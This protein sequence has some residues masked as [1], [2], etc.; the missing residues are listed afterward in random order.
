M[1]KKTEHPQLAKG[2][3]TKAQQSPP[4]VDKNSL[5]LQGRGLPVLQLL[6]L[7]AVGLGLFVFRIA[8]LPLVD[9]DE[10]RCA[11]IVQEMQAT[12]NWLV[13]H[14]EGQLYFDKP[15]P[16]FWLAALV[17]NVTGS[18]EL[19]GRLIAA[20]AGLAAVLVSWAWGRRIFGNLAGLLAGLVLATSVE[21]FFIARW[22]RMDMPFV[23]AIWA[24]IW[25]LWRTERSGAKPSPWRGW[26]GFYALAG[27]ATLFKG[28]AGLGLPML[29]V[30][31]YLLVSGQSR[32]LLGMFHPLGIGLYLLIAAPW[33]V[34]ISLA[35]PGY[36]YEFFV[37]QN[38]FR[39]VGAGNLGHKWP[40]ILYVPILLAGLLPWTIYLPGAVV[41]Y[42]PRRWQQLKQ[43]SEFLLLW[44]IALVTVVFFSFSTTKLPSY[45][46]L[47]FPPLAILIGGLIAEWISTPAPDL[48]LRHSAR[49]LLTA[50]LVIAPLIL[51]G[52]EVYLQS[53][54]LWIVLPI[55][56]SVFAAWRMY[57]SLVR[58]NR[59]MLVGW[60]LVG[61][62]AMFTFVAGHTT[63]AAY[64]LLSTKSLAALVPPDSDGQRKICFWET[65][66]YSF[67]VY[68]H[69]LKWTKFRRE[70]PD[71]LGRLT[72]L[73]DSDKPVYCLVSGKEQL[74]S[75]KSA[76]PNRLR[77]LGQTKNRWLVTNVTG[78]E[79]ISFSNINNMARK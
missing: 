5:R 76:C 66:K 35:E 9:P 23:A 73:M 31:V 70:D 22:Y 28:P 7:I 67:L 49:A 24:A 52:T 40:G 3:H 17:Q 59:R 2:D 37:Q 1:M 14:L 29:I 43:H 53:L 51:I 64:E 11:L 10:A 54:D 48:L 15:A 50:V 16:F 21:F 42:F 6:L 45:I 79:S 25:W 32:R 4:E 71:G 46:L 39:Y 69:T 38:L 41:R 74:Q 47:T 27:V 77:M 65:K 33:Y 34:A 19:G 78:P 63:S 75:L 60:G 36:A 72:R 68:T 62:I 20:L 18:Q 12:G 44:L 26:V 61:I 8:S 58:D 57:A 55:G 56:I 30:I 13:P